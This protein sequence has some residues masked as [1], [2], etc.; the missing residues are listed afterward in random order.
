MPGKTPQ[1]K[2]TSIKVRIPPLAEQLT[3]LQVA[4]LHRKEMVL[5][6][7]LQILR[8]NLIQNLLLHSIR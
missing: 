8:D 3:I 2:I 6:R 7:E 1:R 5:H 4:A